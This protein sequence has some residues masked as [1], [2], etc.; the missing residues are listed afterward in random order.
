MISFDGT[1]L[2]I[3]YH[4]ACGS[5]PSAMGGTLQFIERLLQ[6]E[7]DPGIRVISF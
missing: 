4:G 3:S 6:E 5:C 1:T 7:V 2:E